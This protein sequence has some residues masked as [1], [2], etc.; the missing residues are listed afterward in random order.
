MIMTTGIFAPDYSSSDFAANVYRLM[1]KNGRNVY[2]SMV[3]G[4]CGGKIIGTGDGDSS[5]GCKLNKK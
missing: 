3:L 1:V 4:G 2:I 5:S